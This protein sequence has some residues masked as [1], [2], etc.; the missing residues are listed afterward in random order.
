MPTIVKPGRRGI[1]S[2]AFEALRKAE[3]AEKRQV[4]AAD[5]EPKPAKKKA[6]AKKAK[7]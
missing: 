1:V 3:K 6:A 4:N 5:P 7:R 2:M